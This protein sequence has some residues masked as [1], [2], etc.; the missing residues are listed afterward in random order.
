MQNLLK[1]VKRCKKML[2]EVKY[3]KRSENMQKGAQKGGPPSKT[4]G[5]KCFS[6]VGPLVFV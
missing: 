5:N 3:V 6:Q 2:Q 4:Q 1:D